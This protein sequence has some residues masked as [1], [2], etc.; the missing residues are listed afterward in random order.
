M[1]RNSRIKTLIFL[2]SIIVFVLIAACVVLVV[3]NKNKKN[4]SSDSGSTSEKQTEEEIIR[5]ENMDPEIDKPVVV[6]IDAGHG[7]DDPGSIALDGRYEKDYNLQIAQAMKDELSKYEGVRVY[8]TRSGDE[9]MSNTARSMV[10]AS[11]HAD[12]LI[13]VHNN[14]GSDTN[15]GCLVYR[16]LN[17]Y[18]G[19]KT[20]EMGSLI[21]ENLAGLGLRN[22]GVLTREST[23]DAGEDYYTL[24]GEGVRAGVPSIIVE[25]CFLSNE[26][27]LAFINQ[28][29][30]TAKM[31][32]ADAKAV[33]TYFKLNKRI[34][35]ADGKTAVA[36]LPGY[37]V[38]LSSGIIN[39]S[40]D[41]YAIDS[42]IATVSADGVVTAVNPGTT[43]VV[44]KDADGNLVE[45]IIVVKEKTQATLVGG[46]TNTFFETPD[47]FRAYNMADAYG[48]ITYTDGTSQKVKPINIGAINYDQVGIQDIEITYAEMKGTVRAFMKQGYVPTVTM[49][50]TEADAPSQGTTENTTVAPESESQNITAPSRNISSDK[51][52]TKSNDKLLRTVIILLAV[53][54]VVV[55]VGIILLL[56]EN[57]LRK[58]RRRRRRR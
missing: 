52:T 21:T 45:T 53:L 40:V 51:K 33:V 57:N 49:P 35:N 39:E 41:W 9:W 16:S 18:Y 12:F 27:D 54:L 32:Q 23:T 26:S 6:V 19:E 48:F 34:A 31:G 10:A 11:L 37:S 30:M 29:G 15:S 24:I 20:N 22:G 38:A 1:R 7:E 17:Q 44:Y 3:V 13:S 36:L 5:S 47:E 4:K 14:S 25:H 2:V 50:E 8:L 46:L 28:D 56:I 55:V 42:S 43:N 58:K